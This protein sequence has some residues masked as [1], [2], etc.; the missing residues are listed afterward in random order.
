MNELLLVVTIGG[1]RVAIKASEVESVIELD[2]MTPVPR[3]PAFIAGL[4]ALRSRALTV[5][6]CARSLELDRS[7]AGHATSKVAV[8]EHEGHLYGLLVDAVDDVVECDAEPEEVRAHLEGG[9]KRATLG[10]VET[11]AGP[12]LLVDAAALVD[13]PPK[14][15][16]A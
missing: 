14:Q 5:I 4:A 2:T 13:G 16:A 8:V 11:P 12:L 1:R 15:K 9:W 7:S 3:A 10:S 6:D